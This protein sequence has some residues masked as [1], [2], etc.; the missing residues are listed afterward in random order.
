MC[1]YKEKGIISSES[2]QVS[3]AG[4]LNVNKKVMSFPNFA[5]A[6][7]IKTLRL[8]GSKRKWKN[9]S[10]RDRV[11]ELVPIIFKKNMSTG[12]SIWKIIF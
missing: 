4:S 12:N 8:L 7:S 10:T 5:K 2:V 6:I 1:H 11:D 9:K 3:T